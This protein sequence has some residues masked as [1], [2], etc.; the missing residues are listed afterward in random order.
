MVFAGAVEAGLH[1]E[2][3]ETG[4]AERA[5]LGV[6]GELDDADFEPVGGGYVVVV[7]GVVFPG[8]EGETGG[9]A[10]VDCGAVDLFCLGPIWSGIGILPKEAENALTGWPVR[11]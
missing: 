4:V 11:T 9:V 5:P 3:L 2:S 8:E 1:F 6:D 10:E 7:L